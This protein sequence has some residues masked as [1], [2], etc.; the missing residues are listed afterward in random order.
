MGRARNPDNSPPPLN[1][2]A[3]RETRRKIQRQPGA[4]RTAGA[5]SGGLCL[6]RFCPGSAEI[7]AIRPR[8]AARTGLPRLAIPRRKG[9]TTALSG[10]QLRQPRVYRAQLALGS[11]DS[12]H[13][14]RSQPSRSRPVRTDAPE[15][16][17]V[18]QAVRINFVHS[19][20]LCASRYC[21][22]P[23]RNGRKRRYQALRGIPPRFLPENPV[24]TLRS[25]SV[26]GH[27][28]SV[29]TRGLLSD[30]FVAEMT[31]DQLDSGNSCRVATASGRGRERQ[32]GPARPCSRWPARHQRRTPALSLLQIPPAH[33]LYS[34]LPSLLPA[35]ANHKQSDNSALSPAGII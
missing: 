34:K 26:G 29:G 9:L 12:Q 16:R 15:S 21:A 23:T 6:R 27:I 13:P 11:P 4:V 33:T 17:A 10:R 18:A 35:V 24:R 7:G 20:G 3:L 2:I 30:C 31:G 5:R 25:A 14:A 28:I 1:A 19:G 32:G 22:D 8:A